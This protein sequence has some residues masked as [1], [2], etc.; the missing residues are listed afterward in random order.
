MKILQCDGNR[1]VYVFED[2]SECAYDDKAR[3]AMLKQKKIGTVDIEVRHEYS[4]QVDAEP[5]NPKFFTQ[6]KRN[7]L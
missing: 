2:F 1:R 3:Y 6:S 7:K 5:V 4:A